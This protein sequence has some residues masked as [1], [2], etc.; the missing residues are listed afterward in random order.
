MEQLKISFFLTSLVVF[1]CLI[2]ISHSIELCN[3]KDKNALLQIKNQ[4]GPNSTFFASWLPNTDCCKT[5]INIGCDEKTNRVKILTIG[6]TNELHGQIPLIVGDLTALEQLWFNDL[7][8]LTGPIPSSL[9]NLVNLQELMLSRTNLTG[10]IPSF[11]GRLKNLTNLGLS[12]NHLSGPIPPSLSLLTNLQQ[13]MLF[14]NQLS[15]QIP[16]SFGSFK[17]LILFQAYE[18]LLTGPLPRTLSKT[19]LT[20]LDLSNNNLTG[21]ASILFGSNQNL[22]L[23]NMSKNAI[24]FDLTKVVFPSKLQGLDLSQNMIYGSLPKQLAQ[25]PLELFNVSYNQLC[26]P[27]PNGKWLTKFKADSFAHNKCLCGGPL[28]ACT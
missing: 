22:I 21:D 13:L 9:S 14:K 1:S 4:L 2:N 11:L 10:S 3:P 17:N 8:G 5:W 23:L 25:L 7:P 24:S 19:G 16:A 26:G 15:G 27:I 18:N 20:W 6:Q 28:P 12:E